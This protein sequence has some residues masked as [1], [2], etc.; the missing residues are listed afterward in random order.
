MSDFVLL[1]KLDG[2]SVAIL[3]S[4]IFHIEE[5]SDQEAEWDLHTKIVYRNGYIGVRNVNVKDSIHS[6]L[7]MLK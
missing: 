1:T 6:V 3:K 2:K 5:V 4:E 7:E